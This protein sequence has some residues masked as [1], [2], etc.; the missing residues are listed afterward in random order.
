MQALDAQTGKP[1]WN[2]NTAAGIRNQDR[3]VQRVLL[4]P[5]ADGD[6]RNDVYVVSPMFMQQVNKTWV[7]VDVLSGA[8]GE[9][10]RSIKSDAPVFKERRT[11]S[12]IDLESPCF[13]GVGGDGYPRLVVATKNVDG[14]G[15]SDRQSTLILST[16]TG[17]TTHVGDQLE[18][19]LQAD[20]DGDGD[21]DLFLIKP[22]IRNSLCEAGQLVSLKSYGGR[23]H[24]LIGLRVLPTDDVNC[25]GVRDLLTDPK[26][27]TTLQALSGATG[28]RLWQWEYQPLGLSINPLNNDVDGD[29]INDY[30]VANEL[31]SGLGHRLMLTLVSG[32]RGRMLWQI[33]LPTDGY[34]RGNIVEVKC[35][36]MNA[37]GKNDIVLIHRFRNL[38]NGSSDASLCVSC[39]DGSSGDE[40]WRSEL[41]AA[42][43]GTARPS[44]ELAEYPMQ[45]VDVDNDGSLD[46][47]F[48]RF[49]IDGTEK[50]IALCGHS[51]DLLWEGITEDANVFYSPECPLGRAEVLATGPNQQKQ[52]VTATGVRNSKAAQTVK[53][54]FYDFEN[55]HPVSYWSAEGRFR[56]YPRFSGNPPGLWNGIPF[57]I[58]AGEK[59][60]TGI[61]VQDPNALKLQIVVLD[62]SQAKSHR[63]ASSRRSSA[64][65]R[66]GRL[67]VDRSIFNC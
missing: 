9:L 7:F 38:D 2:K 6:Q 57:E 10:I 8:T 27:G 13:L 23:E 31:S 12:G 11:Y 60:Y 42:G 28:E 53:V 30:L 17:E 41:A 33:D 45:I 44:F 39:F 34:R 61:C 32:S 37:N 21:L 22:R 54:T 36:D 50:L 47:F 59:R 58:T 15:N 24:K 66:W 46:V 29:N 48:R 14:N 19:P 26:S 65:Q 43:S 63:S 3:Q 56:S 67:R 16:G 25:D 35:D 1:I 5:D 40:R 55:E 49:E 18:H 20:G 52:F 4:G 64:G 51:G 62:S